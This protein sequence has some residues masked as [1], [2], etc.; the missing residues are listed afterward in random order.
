MNAIKKRLQTLKLE[1]DLAMDKADLCD[2]QAKEA[3][4]REEKLRDEVREL[5]KKLMQ[6]EHDLEVSKAQLIKSNRN[7][8]IKER[9]YIVTQSELAVLNR[10]MQQCMQNLEKSEE[11]RLSAQVKLAQVIETAEDAK[12]ICKVLEN[13]SKLDEERMDQL[14]TQLK[15]ARLIAEDADTKSDEI[16]RKLAFVEDE[17]EA[18]EERVKSSEAK[19]LEREDELF[20]VGNIFKS[21]E[22]SEEKANQRVEEFKAQLKELKVKLKAVEKRAI[23][24]EKTVKI[25]TKE[26][27][28]REDYLLKEKEKYKYICDD[29]DSTF[30]ELTGY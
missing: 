27:D 5:A 8:E 1:K 9:V 24:A 20:I 15:E 25:F 29:L 13:R 2:Q 11:R 23:I 16:S 7:L 30:S 12:R 18:A 21:L 26:M 17:L 28:K 19:I 3:N 14:M 10:K 4:R 6:M 22:V